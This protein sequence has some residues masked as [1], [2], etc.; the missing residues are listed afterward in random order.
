MWTDAICVCMLPFW[1]KL[2]SQMWHLNAF[3][4]SWIVAI[5]VDHLMTLGQNV[6]ENP[7]CAEKGQEF[8]TL[9][10]FLT[11]MICCNMPFHTSNLCK[12]IITNW[13][14]EWLLS[15]IYCCN[16]HLHAFFFWVKPPPQ[17]EHLNGL[18][19]FV[20]SCIAVKCPNKLDFF[21]KLAGH[22]AHA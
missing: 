14:L 6:E 7:F 5:C 4:P 15:L 11:L 22:M 18:N 3:C 20:F 12:A 19:F 8:V 21:S 2:A 10:C 9:K 16:M 17:M 13:T 1:V